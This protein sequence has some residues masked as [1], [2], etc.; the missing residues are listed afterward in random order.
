[1]FNIWGETKDLYSGNGSYSLG[2]VLFTFD[3]KK[4]D[5]TKNAISINNDNGKQ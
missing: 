2:N 4:K 1:V 5:Q 3:G